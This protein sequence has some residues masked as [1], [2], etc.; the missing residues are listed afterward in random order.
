MYTVNAA[1]VV[2]VM[3]Y[4]QCYISLFS[5]LSALAIVSPNDIVLFRK[6]DFVGVRV[7]ADIV[8][9]AKSGEPVLV[10]QYAP[11]EV[12]RLWST[13]EAKVSRALTRRFIL[14]H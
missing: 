3:V 1:H 4:M 14:T 2:V 5:S 10:I 13:T 11:T 7:F 12:V 8:T 9:Y 6:G